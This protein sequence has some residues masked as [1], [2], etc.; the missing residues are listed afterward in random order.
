MPH[1]GYFSDKYRGIHY[2]DPRLQAEFERLLAEVDA[3]ERARAPSKQRFEEAERDLDV[4]AVSRKEF[5]SAENRY[6]AANNKLAAA[7]RAVDQFLGRYKN[8]RV[9][10]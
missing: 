4:G 6:I 3:A 5:E 10:E 7:L 8:Y 1:S 9:V 2:D